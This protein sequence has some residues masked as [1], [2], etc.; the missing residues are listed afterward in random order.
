M[1]TADVLKAGPQAT[2]GQAVLFARAT[3]S[4]LSVRHSD[5]SPPIRLELER[6]VAERWPQTK[7][8]CRRWV[9]EKK[10]GQAL[11]CLTTARGIKVT[12]C[13][14]SPGGESQPAASR[15]RRDLSGTG[16]LTYRNFRAKR[17]AISAIPAN[18]NSTNVEGSGTG[19]PSTVRPVRAKSTNSPILYVSNPFKRAVLPR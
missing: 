5:A 8:G 1:S 4:T 10:E 17:V 12:F 16:C 7:S 3:R 15:G 9:G 18:P 11:E 19:A 14:A 13:E 2:S 6:I